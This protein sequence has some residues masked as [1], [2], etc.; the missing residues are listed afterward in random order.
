[1]VVWWGDSVTQKGEKM[2]EKMDEEKGE[3]KG[4]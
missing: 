4:D 1:M 2:N 3:E